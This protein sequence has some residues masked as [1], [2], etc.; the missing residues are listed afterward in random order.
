MGLKATLE[1]WGIERVTELNWG[2]TAN[3]K[4]ERTNKSCTVVCVPAQH[5]SQRGVADRCKV[6]F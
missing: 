5:W 1:G 3:V 2:E 4:V 6:D